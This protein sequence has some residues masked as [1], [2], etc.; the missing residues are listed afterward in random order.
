M[1]VRRRPEDA[2]QRAVFEHLRTRGAADLFFLH[3]PNGGYRHAYEAAILKGLGV[4]AG[5]PDV[6]AIK[7]GRAYG[8]ELKTET[9]RTTPAQQSVL[10]AMAKAGAVVAVAYGLDAALMQLEAWELLRGRAG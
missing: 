6:I 1:T 4:V 3:I 5:A 2:I 10:E 7:G 8:L 9:G